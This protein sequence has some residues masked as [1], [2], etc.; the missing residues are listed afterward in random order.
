MKRL[1]L[2]VA[3]L[4]L[5]AAAARA[6]EPRLLDLAGGAFSFEK[7]G[8]FA[9]VRCADKKWEGCG[10]LD[11]LA[12]Q[13]DVDWAALVAKARAKKKGEASYVDQFG[14][15][16]K[17]VLSAHEASAAPLF[18]GYKLE[19]R[20]S[21]VKVDVLADAQ[22]WAAARHELG[23]DKPKRKGLSALFQ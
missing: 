14:G 11:G 22:Q 17:I 15:L 4:A 23:L 5:A 12:P 3:V 18:P 8:R 9:F 7:D 6:E 2:A 21:S 20:G 10:E 19:G 1:A 16:W 13:L